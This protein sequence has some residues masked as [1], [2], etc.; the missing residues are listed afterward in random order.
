[1]STN[2]PSITHT[3]THIPVMLNKVLDGLFP[4][5]KSD[6]PDG[7]VFIDGTLGGGG[8]SRKI[9]KHL[10]PKDQ[11]I[12]VDQDSAILQRT[13]Q[14][15]DK[16]AQAHLGKPLSAVGKTVLANFSELST[17]LSAS[18][19]HHPITGG[20]L[21]DL[22]VSSFQLD[23]GER[24]FSF[25]KEAPLDMRMSTEAEQ[26]AADIIATYSEKELLHIFQE[27]GEERMSKTLAKEIVDYRKSQPIETTTQ[28]AELVH[29]TYD[30]ILK[31]KHYR[32]HPA[33]CVFQA[34]RIEVNQE[35]AHLEQL[36]D[37]LPQL[38]APGARAVIISFHSLEDR[39]VK[40]RFRQLKQQHGFTILTKKP[41]L[42]T[43]AEISINP[44]SRSAKLRI[45]EAI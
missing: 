5:P 22:G 24:G 3:D 1:M 17:V 15:L 4:Q 2:D 36:L 33:T 23:T 32:I 41:L 21:L 30:R 38:L 14:K 29:A 37:S 7:K 45:I 26:T 20:L 13:T 19:S 28:L 35:L 43:E 18:E 8:H 25:R 40:H 42:P 9:I 16:W 27:Y 12:G 31:R 11:W 44:R 10:G 39:I 34:L 6:S